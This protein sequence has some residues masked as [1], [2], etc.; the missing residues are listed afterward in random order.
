MSKLFTIT[1][2]TPERTIYVG[3]VSSLIAPCHFGYAGVLANHAPFMSTMTPGK[4][5]LKEEAGRRR[6]FYSKDKGFLEVLRNN[7]NLLVKS[8]DTGSLQ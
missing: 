1:I 7:V 3:K 6:I 5:I 8:I 2:L 4:I